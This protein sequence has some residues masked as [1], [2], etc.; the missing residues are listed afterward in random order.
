MGIW[1][2]ASA[3]PRR[4]LAYAASVEGDALFLADVD[5]PV[6][7]SSRVI[8]FAIPHPFAWRSRHGESPA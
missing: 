7:S 4:L 2:T 1:R 5:Q 3:A 6:T 8:A